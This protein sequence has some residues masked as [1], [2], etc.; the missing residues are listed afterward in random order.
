MN[1]G[2]IT[3]PICEGRGYIGDLSYDNMCKKCLGHGSFDWIENITGL[4]PKNNRALDNI[5]TKRL[6]Q[7]VKHTLEKV[8]YK[9]EP[10]NKVTMMQRTSYI[11]EILRDL[12]NRKLIF[13][14]KVD[15]YKTPDMEHHITATLKPNMV[16]ELINI[17]VVVT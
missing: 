1:D 14:Y 12:K 7:Y 15:D 5:N 4:S 3:C 10:N 11:G 2:L 13:D 6:V 17:N 16:S 8:C 9:F